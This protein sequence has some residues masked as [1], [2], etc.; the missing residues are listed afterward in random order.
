MTTTLTIRRLDERVKERLRLAAAASGHS[1][2]EEARQILS[3]ALLQRHDS[4]AGFASTMREIFADADL[5]GFE[6][7]ARGGA[8]RDLF[9]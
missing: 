4:R 1:M 9:E 7:P 8:V 2:E 3:R 6:T 5:E